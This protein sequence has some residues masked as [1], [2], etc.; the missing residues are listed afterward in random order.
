METQ[1]DGEAPRPVRALVVEDEGSAARVL[2]RVLAAE[3][4]QVLVARSAEEA[5]NQDLGFDIIFTDITLPGMTGLRAIGEFKKRDEAPV[6]VMTGHYDD[7]IRKDAMLLGATGFLEK[8]FDM[9]RV[10]AIVRA[11][12]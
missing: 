5:L 12:R 10:R 6:I 11:L 2:S 3:G 8:P 4:C 9:E 1:E 7:E